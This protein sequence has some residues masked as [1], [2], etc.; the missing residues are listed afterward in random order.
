MT[1][2]ALYEVTG[3]RHQM[4]HRITLL[5][6]IAF[7]ISVF[8]VHAS[9]DIW[10]DVSAPARGIDSK[11]RHFEADKKAL[12][13]QLNQVPHEA[14]GDRSRSI[15]LPLPDG[16]LASFVIVESPIMKPR[17]AARYPDI[18]TFKVYGIDDPTASGRV[19]ITPQGFH[20]MLF[21]AKGRLFIDPDHSSA[22]TD[23]YLSRYR[24]GQPS[25]RFSCDVHKSDFE[26]QGDAVIADRS[27]GRISR[28]LL[29][30]DLAVAATEEYVVALGGTVALAQAGIV[31]AIN[32]INEIYERDLGIRLTLVG[33]N[34][35][36]IEN[37]DN[38][39]FSNGDTFTMLNENQPWLDS[40]STKLG[41]DYDIGHVF[42]TG[43]GGS[44]FLG[45]V[46]N[47]ASK[48]KGATG[49]FVPI[50]DPFYID[51]VA[52]EIGHQFNAD[53]S[54]NG[55]TSSC[56]SGNRHALTAFE[57]G[58]GSTIMAYAGICGVES[59]QLNSDAT[60]HAGSIAQINSFSGFAGNGNCFTP[61]ATN[62][63]NN[64]DPVIDPVSDRT[65]PLNTAFVLTGS[66]IDAESGM[67]LSYQWDQMDV[68]TPT[69]AVSYGTDLGDNPLFR[70]YVP[71]ST[72]GRD[73]PALGTQVQGLYDDAEVVPCQ[74]R[75]LDFR[76]T[77]RD[78]DSGQ[79]VEDVRITVS[80]S[81]G[82]FKV[83]SQAQ[84]ET[85]NDAFEVNWDVANT[86][87]APVSCA[88]V[89]VELLAFDD[90]SYTNHAVHT[91]V[92]STPNNGSV[93]IA[94]TADSLLAPARG[95]LRVRCLNNYFYAL[96]Q[97]NLQFVGTKVAPQTFFDADDIATFFNNNGT[98][99]DVA[100][101][102]KAQADVVATDRSSGGGSGAFDVIWL[103]L[104]AGLAATKSRLRRYGM[105]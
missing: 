85:I 103:L 79:A 98:T 62:P 104:L 30:Y 89:A 82:P 36:L 100:P 57:P 19:D 37:G 20:A 43:I 42:G 34:D 56:G 66:A 1:K 86:D 58:S 17:L 6:A 27:G 63:L 4:I 35:Q 67:T 102:C 72:A 18:K 14:L 26:N 44:A 39:S 47:S 99:G 80:G 31:T 41:F 2:F 49:L 12:R 8:E 50:G 28:I 10:R 92:A 54:F 5:I 76:L 33:N 38:V 22:Q 51:Y 23:Q 40:Q 90:A 16:S 52:H 61:I 11:L 101:V 24:G 94:P 32:R 105:Q 88:N 25:Q 45:S 9:S 60:F 97:G 74:A 68:G 70:S 64:A 81:A 7:S 93:V 55:T 77:A 65:I 91:L 71:Q 84:G 46:C 83:T 75:E 95:R 78:G 13:G 15:K 59:L 69:D 96:S 48:A 29:E 73:F 87:I 21:T 53:H 3:Q